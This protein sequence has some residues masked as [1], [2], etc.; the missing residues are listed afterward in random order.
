MIRSNVVAIALCVILAAPL[1]PQSAEPARFDVASVKANKSTA[2]PISNF[3]IGP[4]DAYTPNGGYFNATNLPLIAYIAFAYKLTGT[5]MNYMLEHAPEWVTSERFDVQARVAGNPGKDQMRLLMRALL[6]ERFKLSTHEESKE[7][8]VGALVLVKDG[9]LGPQLQPHAADKPCPTDA[10]PGLLS[11]DPRF[12][13]L[14]GG[15]LQLQAST[16]GRIRF[17]ARNVTIDFISRTLGSGTSYG[18]PMVDKTEL[19]GTYDFNLEWIPDI[20]PSEQID[21]SGPTFEQAL[22]EQ[23]GFKLESQK[24]ALPVLVLDH[25]ERPTDN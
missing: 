2:N 3:P 25:V 8:P 12:P 15:L 20:D 16:P 14:C 4:G 23:L 22:R 9:K 1:L 18:R 17:A 10:R 11:D 21:R 24:A 6:A 19:Q 7:M 13:L 5:R